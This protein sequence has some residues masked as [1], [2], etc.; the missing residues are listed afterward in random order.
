MQLNY[1]LKFTIVIT[2]VLALAFTASGQQASKK[3]ASVLY[4]KAV[5]NRQAPK[6]ITGSLTSATINS[7][8]L[9]SAQRIIKAP[10]PKLK[11]DPNATFTP[12][13][14]SEQEGKRNLQSNSVIH[15][16]TFDQRRHPIKPNAPSTEQ[17]IT[18]GRE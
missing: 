12:R 16:Q 4:S 5:G 11:Q 1:K 13:K 9:P 14:V 2:G 17:G 3:P 7:K 6:P 8:K 10:T 15:K 18:P